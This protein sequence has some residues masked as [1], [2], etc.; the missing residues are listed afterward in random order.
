[1][2]KLLYIV[3]KYLLGIL[4]VFGG[5]AHFTK[6]EF[7]LKAMPSYLPFHEFIVYASGVLE[8]VLGVLLVIY[9][10]TRKAAIGI[11]LLF[12]AIFP[13]NINMYLNHT[14]FPDM[15]ETA[16]LVRLP[17][18]LILIAWAYIYTRKTIKD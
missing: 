15:S 9:K 8:I 17:I 11:I 2:K 10:T 3:F 4:L 16:L 1:M 5:I 13:A 7:Y 14:D 18:Q 6:T 12:I